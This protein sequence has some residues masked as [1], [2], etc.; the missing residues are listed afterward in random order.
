VVALWPLDRKHSGGVGTN[1]NSTDCPA[2]LLAS[3]S[4]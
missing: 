1:Q 4:W 3:A 2:L